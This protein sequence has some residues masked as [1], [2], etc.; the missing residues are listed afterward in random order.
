MRQ[1]LLSLATRLSRTPQ[2]TARL[3]QARSWTYQAFFALLFVALASFHGSHL[4][5]KIRAWQSFRPEVPLPGDSWSYLE[6]DPAA[7][8]CPKSAK[9]AATCLANPANPA[10]WSAPRHRD[11]FENWSHSAVWPVRP[12]HF[13]L[14]VNVSPELQARAREAGASSLLLGWIDAPYRIWVNGTQVR[15]G[16]GWTEVEPIF[17]TVTASK[18][19]PLKPLQIAIEFLGPG[20]PGN[21]ADE[22]NSSS[23]GE[24]FVTTAS[25]TVYRTYSSFTSRVRPFALASAYLV[26]SLIFFFVWAPNPLRQEYLFLSLYALV[27]FGYQAQDIDLW[28]YDLEPRLMYFLSS[29]FVFYQGA[30]A[31]LLGLAF[32]R[33]RAAFLRAALP[34]FFL[35]PIALHLALWRESEPDALRRAF[36]LWVLPVGCALAALACWLEAFHLH[37]RGKTGA[38]LPVRLRRLVLFG[39]GLAA[40]GLFYEAESRD[41]LPSLYRFYALTSGGE[42]FLLILFVGGIALREFGVQEQLLSRTPVSPY[43]R[44]PSLPERVRGALLVVDL[45]GSERLFRWG[46]QEGDAGKIVGSCVSHLWTAVTDHG[47]IVLQTEGDGLRAFFDADSCPD[48]LAAALGST[49]AMARNLREVDG[50]IRSEYPI[51]ASMPPLRFRG[52]IAQGEIRPVWQELG[53]NRQASWTE[54]GASNAFV[55]SARLMEAEK[56]LGPDGSAVVIVSGSASP[57]ALVGT[58]LARELDVIGKHSVHYRVDV[59]APAEPGATKLSRA[60]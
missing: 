46:A 36:E 57:G 7:G 2:E 44:R 54:A 42:G 26:V 9:S 21:E 16:R 48:P 27:S 24:G 13:W 41:W 3:R 1:R 17:L 40:L 12:D 6:A 60:A 15:E 50:W 31:F 29:T 18:L 23:G 8:P 37:E 51:A 30:F 59:Y 39:A 58:W 14:G 33:A 56:G 38:R 45:K 52:G 28:A 43:H 5:S 34:A 35:A 49:D 47:G 20:K 25:E 4:F 32:A 11:A 55:D 19:A 53:G 10:L 22:F